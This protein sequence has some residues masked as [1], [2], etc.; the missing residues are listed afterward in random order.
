[1]NQFFIVYV[2]IFILLSFGLLLGYEYGNLLLAVTD[3]APAMKSAMKSLCVIF[4]KMIHITCLAHAMHRLAETIRF[5]FKNVNR[6]ISSMKAVFLKS[7]AR[8]RYFHGNAAWHY[9]HRQ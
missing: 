1:M 7:P 9:R 6:L 4:P 8:I 2:Y 5:Q 3:A